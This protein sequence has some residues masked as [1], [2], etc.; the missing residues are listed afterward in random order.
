MDPQNP[1]TILEDWVPCTSP[2]TFTGLT[3]GNAYYFSV[4][5]KG[6]V[7]NYAVTRQ[8]MITGL[9]L[10]A[11]PDP[12][13][14]GSAVTFTATLL[15][16]SGIVPGGTMSFSEMVYS[17]PDIWTPYLLG[18]GSGPIA[19][20]TGS[21]AYTFSTSALTVG[22]HDITAMYTDEDGTIKGLIITQEVT[23]AIAQVPVIT[24]QPTNQSVCAGSSVSFA[25][26][27]SRTPTPTIQW[28]VSSDGGTTWN[29]ISSA[30]SATYAFTAA[31]GD[32]G[33]RHN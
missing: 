28:Q 30:T 23:E 21:Y 31:V 24:T 6:A 18:L 14:F 26:A 4:R 17:W 33:K 9:P 3:R 27:A 7:E 13:E 5:P 15:D 12:S 29:N 22:Y 25:A 16:D 11:S 1:A 20:G 8:W 32:S 19:S 10:T 2:C